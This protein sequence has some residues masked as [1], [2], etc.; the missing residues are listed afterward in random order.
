MNDDL[1]G[2]KVYMTGLQHHNIKEVLEYMGPKNAIHFIREENEWG[3]NGF[4]WRA[5]CKGSD[6]GY[7]PEQDTIRNKWRVP[8]HALAD[9]VEAIREANPARVL[10]SIVKV[11][12]FVVEMKVVRLFEDEKEV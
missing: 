12:G 1:I 9:V 5:V 4:A 10:C 3:S 7:M 11:D 2:K 6:I 8:D